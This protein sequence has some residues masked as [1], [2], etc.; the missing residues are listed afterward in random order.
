MKKKLKYDKN[1]ELSRNKLVILEELVSK[2]INKSSM[3][4]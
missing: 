3:H 4:E 2:A 1:I